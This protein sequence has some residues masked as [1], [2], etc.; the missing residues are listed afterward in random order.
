MHIKTSLKVILCG[1]LFATA[2]L[3]NA[4]TA[5]L[6]LHSEA[7]DYIGQGK[8]YDITYTPENSYYFHANAYKNSSTGKPDYLSFVLGI[9]QNSPFASLEFSTRGL[10]L[11]MQVGTYNNAERAAF[12]SYSHPGLDVSFAHRGSNRL[13]GS[14]TVTQFVFSPTKGIQN[15]SVNFEQHSEGQRPAL[16]GTFT[17]TD[18]PTPVPEPE[19]YA[20]M[21]AGLGMLVAL[22]RRRAK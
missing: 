3:A 22:K 9:G 7:G 18:M 13:T 14:F 12:A 11:P 16:F 19:T 4:K 10:G 1:I 21:F 15:F 6:V 20:M 17:Y 8:D 2:S 5:H